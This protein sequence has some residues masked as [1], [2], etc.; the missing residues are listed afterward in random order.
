MLRDVEMTEISDGERYRNSDMAKVGCNDCK[1]CCDCCKGM[2]SSIV[3][4]PYDVHRLTGHLNRSF[5][6][7][8]GDALELTVVDGLILPCLAMKGEEE[9][10]T[11]LNE[12]GRCSIHPY[13][14]GICRIFPLGRIYEE[15]GFSYFLQ[16]KECSHSQRTK[17]KVKKWIDTPNLEQYDAF[18]MKWHNLVV[19][20]REQ[21]AELMASEDN[22]AEIKKISMGL[23]Q[24]FYMQAYRDKE[25]FFNE[26]SRRCEEYG[27]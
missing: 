7:L 5:E 4:D 6:S 14:P 9:A 15:D 17:V 26:F 11:F 3:L 18:I 21:V 24:K 22:K 12:E 23:L 20:L 27:K 19:A 10:C 1:G 13:R 2:G 8:I 25:G 16:T